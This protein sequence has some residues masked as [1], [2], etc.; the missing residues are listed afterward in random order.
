MSARITTEAVGSSR[1]H[2]LEGEGSPRDYNAVK[3]LGMKPSGLVADTAP[4]AVS[5]FQWGPIADSVA[6]TH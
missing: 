6:D 4:V 2:R 1:S 5:F 3:D